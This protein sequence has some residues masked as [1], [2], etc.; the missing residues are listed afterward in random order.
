MK[1]QI[2]SEYTLQRQRIGDGSCFLSCQNKT[3]ELLKKITKNFSLLILN[4]L[5][6]IIPMMVKLMQE[7]LMKRE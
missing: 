2:D 3:N 4:F 5:V 7:I 6:M 1:K